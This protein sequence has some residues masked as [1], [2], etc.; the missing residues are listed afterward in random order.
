MRNRTKHML[1]IAVLGAFCGIVAFAIGGWAAASPYV[2]GPLS[3]RCIAGLLCG[4]FVGVVSIPIGVNT[5][6][7]KD[8][9]RTAG[10][11]TMVLVPVSVGAV[12]AVAK[13]G[14]L[15]IAV[16]PLAFPIA[17][18]ASCAVLKDHLPNVLSDG[19]HPLCEKCGYDLTGNESGRCPECGTPVKAHGNEGRRKKSERLTR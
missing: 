3:R 9:V 10:A 15:G 5:L 6:W 12:V 8:V 19:S 14:L 11:L 2:G 16:A 7:R 17:L 4:L 18:Y 13:G 1:L